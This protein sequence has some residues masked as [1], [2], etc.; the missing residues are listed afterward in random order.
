MLF[1]LP[2]I[3]LSFEEMMGKP[4]EWQ[5]LILLGKNWYFGLNKKRL[6]NEEWKLIFKQQ[7]VIHYLSYKPWFIKYSIFFMCWG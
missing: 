3:C 7:Y 6:Q 2:Q 1:Y 5:L 4:D